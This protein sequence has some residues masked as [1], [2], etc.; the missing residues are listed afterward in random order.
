MYRRSLGQ[1]LKKLFRWLKR[2]YPKD[3]ILAKTGIRSVF[4]MPLWKL[5]KV[6]P[7]SLWGFQEVENRL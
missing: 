3:E 4:T 5:W 2:V 1:D 6:R 7:S